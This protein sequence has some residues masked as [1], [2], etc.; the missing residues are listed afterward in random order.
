MPV[1]GLGSDDRRLSGGPSVD[2]CIYCL[3]KMHG[4]KEYPT[5]ILEERTFGPDRT[6]RDQTPTS[7]DTPQSTDPTQEQWS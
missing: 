3:G 4:V 1:E 2:H 7:V 5:R 6:S